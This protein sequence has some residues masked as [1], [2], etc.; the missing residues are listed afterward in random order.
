MKERGETGYHHSARGGERTARKSCDI[1]YGEVKEELML[2]DVNDLNYEDELWEEEKV[3]LK[4]QVEESSELNDNKLDLKVEDDE[5]SA[6][7]KFTRGLPAYFVVDRIAIAKAFSYIQST[8][9]GKKTQDRSLGRE[10][11]VQT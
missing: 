5:D 8:P 6:I 10:G 4:T 1:A 2:E 7:Y 9:R 3:E 11:K